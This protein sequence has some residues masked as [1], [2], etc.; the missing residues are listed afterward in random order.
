[1]VLERNP[2]KHLFKLLEY[3]TY[4]E[5]FLSM[6]QIFHLKFMLHYNS[7]AFLSSISWSTVRK[8][9]YKSANTP[10]EYFPASSGV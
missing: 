5:V 8:A 7:Q 1:M 10:A 2:V 6:M 4:D 3:L 9:F